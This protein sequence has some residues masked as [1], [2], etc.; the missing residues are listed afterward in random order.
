MV[1]APILTAFAMLGMME[2]LYYG[3]LTLKSG[4]RWKKNTIY[5]RTEQKSVYKPDPT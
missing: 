3:I 4:T 1:L 2:M 5:F